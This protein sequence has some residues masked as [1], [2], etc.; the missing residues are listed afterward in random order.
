[1]F[2]LQ[3]G[4]FQIHCVITI[5]VIPDTTTIQQCLKIDASKYFE[6]V[7]EYV[8]VFGLT[9]GPWMTKYEVFAEE[10]F[11]YLDS[12]LVVVGNLNHALLETHNR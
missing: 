6:Y 5:T 1:M 3:K 7:Y 10:N 2:F 12:I 9:G 8:S 11:L 4:P